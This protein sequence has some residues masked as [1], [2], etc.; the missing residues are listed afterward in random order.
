MNCAAVTLTTAG[1]GSGGVK[2]MARATAYASRPGLF[3]ANVGAAGG[4]C[5]TEEMFDVVY[6]EPG[7]DVVND[8][9]KPKVPTCGVTQQVSGGGSSALSSSGG[10]DGGIFSPDSSAG[11]ATE[12]NSSARYVYQRKK[13]CGLGS[14]VMTADSEVVTRPLPLLPPHNQQL[15]SQLQ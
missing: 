3:I 4:G 1:G 5:T 6:P 8:S 12:S 2:K 15:L 11:A 10:D 9:S 14:N 13:T 7:P